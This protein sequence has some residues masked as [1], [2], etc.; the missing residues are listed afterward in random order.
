VRGDK[1]LM[2]CERGGQCTGDMVRYPGRRGVLAR[3]A[4]PAVARR[5]MDGACVQRGGLQS[6][7]E[8]CEGVLGISGT[9]ISGAAELLKSL[10]FGR[11]LLEPV[12]VN[13][14]L[15][16][17]VAMFGVRQ[18]PAL[19]HATIGGHRPLIRIVRH[20]WS[21]CRRIGLGQDDLRFAQRC[22]GA[23]APLGP[24]L[25]ELLIELIQGTSERVI[26]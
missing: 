13:N 15:R 4:P 24:R 20:Q 10:G 16:L 6:M 18:Q 22:G 25:N 19:G 14:A 3:A 21:H 2:G 1:R 7:G 11:A 26:M 8:G 12:L 17:G 9:G 23:G 5:R